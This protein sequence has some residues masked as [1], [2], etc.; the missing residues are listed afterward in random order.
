MKI[1]IFRSFDP[2]KL[3]ENVNSFID[4]VKVVNIQLTV[5]PPIDDRYTQYIVLVTYEG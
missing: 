3:E 2:V 5:V 1:K 4:G